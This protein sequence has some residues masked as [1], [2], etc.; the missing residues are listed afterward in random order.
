MTSWNTDFGNKVTFNFL[1]GLKISINSTMSTIFILRQ[2][3]CFFHKK[4]VYS[5][6]IDIIRNILENTQPELQWLPVLLYQLYET[7][8]EA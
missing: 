2:Y 4:I 7:H 8:H 6:A 1:N 3:N 5:K